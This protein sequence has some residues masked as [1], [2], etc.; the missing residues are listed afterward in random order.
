MEEF[1]IP[2]KSPWCY[3]I[4]DVDNFNLQEQLEIINKD[5]DIAFDNLMKYL[6]NNKFPNTDLISNFIRYFSINEPCICDTLIGKNPGYENYIFTLGSEI[7]RG[8]VGAVSLLFN[9]NGEKYIIKQNI[10]V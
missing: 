7:G 6:P 8:K 10:A 9:K 1:Y 2:L 4:S 3:T 5:R